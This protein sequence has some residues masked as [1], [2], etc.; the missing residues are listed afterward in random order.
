MIKRQYDLVVVGCGPA[1]LMTAI[2]A[3]CEGASVLVLDKAPKAALKLRISGKG[4]CNITNDANLPEFIRRFGKNGR[5]LKYA[6]NKFFHPELLELLHT[7]GVK[8]KLERGG[9]Y[10]PQS[11][12]ATDVA[13]ALI[14]LAKT[15]G[16]QIS[17]KSSVD[18]ISYVSELAVYHL[19]LSVNGKKVET[20][21]TYISLAMGGLSYPKT[22]SDGTGFGLAKS[23]GH[24]IT[25]TMPSLVALYTKGNEAGQLE[26]LALKNVEASLWAEGKR[27]QAELGEMVFTD[28]GVSG[29]IILTL[30]RM[31]VP[32][33]HQ[34]RHLLLSLDLK[35]ALEH[36]QLD[37]RL[38]REISEH[39]NRGFKALLLKLLPKSLGPVFQNRL[40]IPED[41]PLN[42]ITTDERKALRL[43]LKS[44]EHKIVG[45]GGYNHAIITK[46][47]VSLR[48]VNPTTMESRI[49]KNL[50]LTGE[51]LDLDADTGGYN[52]QA[53]FSTG[54]VAGRELRK[55]LETN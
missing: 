4:R 41:K 7:Q 2:Q 24:Q 20:T 36:G 34:K 33:L 32:V 8:T 23:L 21:S 25:P 27:L 18:K 37:K 54:W 47:G 16:V 40:R 5:F 48:E 50:F 14:S 52:L 29:P 46:G 11:D 12:L 53:A 10:F 6:F 19:E 31:A 55:R 44:F 39:P 13:D 49:N 28:K 17:I 45:H 42:Q 15:R 9:R 51:M 43:L 1:G 3:I 22:G 38:Q 30:S 35:P 26:G